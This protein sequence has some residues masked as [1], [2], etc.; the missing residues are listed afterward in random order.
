MLFSVCPLNSKTTNGKWEDNAGGYV[1]GAVLQTCL[2]SPGFFGQRGRDCLPCAAG[3][4][5]QSRA[6]TVCQPCNAGTSCSCSNTPS[7][8]CSRTGDPA[9]TSC[10]VCSDNEFQDQ[11][12]QENCK[13]CP[14]GFT[15]RLKPGTSGHAA[16][17]WPVATPGHYVSP[18]DPS[19]VE[20]CQLGKGKISFLGA[21]GEA[22]P[23]GDADLASQLKCV[24]SDSGTLT[25]SA[26]ETRSN[27]CLEAV[28]AICLV[29]AQQLSL[30]LCRCV[31]TVMI[32]FLGWV[33]W[34]WPG[35][36]LQ[37]LQG[38]RHRTVLSPCA[39]SPARKLV[40]TKF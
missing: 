39:R 13:P 34:I 30:P 2:C 7:G 40:P 37:V 15:C 31:S 5:A 19:E 21:R 4:F 11:R 24:I 28:G 29:S 10:P 23:G 36:L 33:L 9:C 16:M 14:E 20:T 3:T 12:G 17:T 38:G 32:A 35:C 8:A 6:S 22:C 27:E 25:A 18:Y 26:D 1:P